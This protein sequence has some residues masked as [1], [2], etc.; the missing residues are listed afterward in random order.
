MLDARWLISSIGRTSPQITQMGSFST[1]LCGIH[2]L[3]LL[4][5]LYFGSIIMYDNNMNS[6]TNISRQ[7]GARRKEL[8]LSLAQ[9]ARRVDTSPA[10]LSR[11]ENGWTRFEVYTLRKLATALDCELVVRLEPKKRRKTRPKESDVVE[12]LRR[13]FWDQD[14][15]VRH[16]KENP[17][18]VV[19]RVLEYGNLEDVHHLVGHMGRDTFLRHVSGARFSSERT[20]VFWQQILSREGLTCTRKYSRKE[21]A[22]SWR[23]SS[24]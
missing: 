1:H 23:S 8:G 17:G 18:W 4:N 20:R 14:L 2:D 13:L 24:R 9:V 5:A 7:L 22:T 19:E 3:K 12:K 21:A 6:A 16:L 11:Y 15:T 10:T